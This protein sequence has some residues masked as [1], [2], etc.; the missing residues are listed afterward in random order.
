[1]VPPGFTAPAASVSCRLPE[2][3]PTTLTFTRLREGR[4]LFNVQAHA[5]HKTVA[6][7][8]TQQARV[9][10]VNAFKHDCFRRVRTG[11]AARSAE[12]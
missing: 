4:T 2:P 11:S 7:Q 9:I 8:V 5:G 6:L 3:A 12:N 1:M 10:I